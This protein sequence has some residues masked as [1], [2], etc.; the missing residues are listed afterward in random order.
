M[1]TELE[2]LG[3]VI[4]FLFSTFFTGIVTASSSLIK[5]ESDQRRAVTRAD[6]DTKRS[7]DSE[8]IKSD[9]Y[10]SR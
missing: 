3:G 6:N 10:G 4:I 9:H 7:N 1:L 2:A 8:P 5:T